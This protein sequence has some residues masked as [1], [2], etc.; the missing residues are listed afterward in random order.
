MKTLLSSRARPNEGTTPFHS[1]ETPCIQ[2]SQFG[3]RAQGLLSS[4]SLSTP[5]DIFNT[6]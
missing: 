2:S 1:A 5:A 3:R 4:A 6:F